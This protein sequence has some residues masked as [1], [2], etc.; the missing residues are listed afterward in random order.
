MFFKD[1]VMVYV[2]RGKIVVN[3]IGNNKEKIINRIYFFVF[4]IN[5]NLVIFEM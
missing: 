3:F 2:K 1:I 5:Y 4:L